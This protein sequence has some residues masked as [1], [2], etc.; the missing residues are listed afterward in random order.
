[1]A[2]NRPGT[3]DPELLIQI[4]ET[5]V[6][7]EAVPADVFDFRTSLYPVS[8][9][10]PPIPDD[11][12]LKLEAA[13]NKGRQVTCPMLK[14]LAEDPTEGSNNDQLGGEE[15]Q[16]EKRFHMFYTDL[17][18]AVA[19]QEYGILA[20]DRIPYQIFEQIGPQLGRYFKQLFGR[21]RRQAI[22]EGISYN[23]LQQPTNLAV[24]YNS[25]MHICGL[26]ND[27]QPSYVLNTQDWV[28]AIATRLDTAGV[29]ANASVDITFL[30]NLQEWA[31]D[32]IEPVTVGGKEMYIVLLPSPQCT[33][34]R[35]PT[36]TNSLGDLW[37]SYAAIPE[38]E[39]MF[40]PDLIG[41]VG[42]LRII[43]DNRYP[44]L[45]PGGTGD[46][47][48]LTARYR[49]MGRQGVQS[50][51]RDKTQAGRQVGSLHGRGGL[52]EWRPEDFHYEYHMD[53]YGKIYGKGL[54]CSVGIRRVEHDYSVA[55]NAGTLQNDGTISL[56]FG[57]PPN[58][59]GRPATLDQ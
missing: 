40:Y 55:A 49:G 36:N 53:N 37:V 48:T 6:K 42:K 45:T 32:F 28:N 59:T 15:Q 52:C 31:S 9:D 19:G 41:D 57:A 24:G 35:N 7:K 16:R 25:N 11:I 46:R 47:R 20:R 51:P 17:S 44:T 50:D 5:D 33:W 21:M 8:E 39:R 56:V 27:Q 13:S 26:N 58:W 54:F 30:M 1:M 43:E 4:F 18:H 23:L 3:L 2:L 34:F 12:Y 38:R 14:E 10:P 29:G 22:L